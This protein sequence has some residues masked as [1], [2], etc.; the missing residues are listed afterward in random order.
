[1]TA[2]YDGDFSELYYFVKKTLRE[3]RGTHGLEER[4]GGVEQGLKRREGGL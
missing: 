1:M 4:W 2:F 3:K